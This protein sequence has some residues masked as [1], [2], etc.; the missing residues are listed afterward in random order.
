MGLLMAAI[1]CALALGPCAEPAPL[2]ASPAERFAISYER[3]GGFAAM[4]QKLT[5]RPGRHATVTALDAHGQRRSV[6]FRVAAKKV[7]RLRAAAEAA[8]IGDLAPSAPGSCAD[9]FVYSVSYRGE[10]A[11]VAEVDVPA[12]MRGL[13]NRAEA[14]IG[15]HLPFH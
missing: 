6:E 2:A 1:S 15:A 8:R 7:E 13:V 3:S 5:I 14:L 4:P 12:R 9:C 11:S 10:T